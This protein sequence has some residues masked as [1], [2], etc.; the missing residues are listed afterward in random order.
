MVKGFAQA[1]KGI[2]KIVTAFLTLNFG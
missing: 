2:V 1:V